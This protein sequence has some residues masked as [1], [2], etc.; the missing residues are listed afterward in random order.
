MTR[1]KW[2]V[3][4]GSILLI[5]LLA[6]G[7]MAVAAEYG[8]KEDPLVTLSYITDVLE[9]E[10]L[11]RVDEAI[12]DKTATLN[13]ELDGKIEE[14]VAKLDEALASGGG[15]ASDLASN[16]ALINAVADAVIEKMGADS[17]ATAPAGESWKVVKLEAGKKLTGKV[18]A[19]VLLRIGSATCLAPSSPGL[20]NLSAGNELAS[21]KALAQNNL[22]M[23]TVEGR[24]ITAGAGGATILA[25][26]EYTIS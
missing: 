2:M 1:N 7:Y 22:Y 23:V 24:G 14:Y 9:P 3:T 5:A 25:C 10:A 19:Q 12:A 18:G 17:S 21:G 16:E 8:S 13:A 26:G 4:V 20:I 6:S 15:S 11:K